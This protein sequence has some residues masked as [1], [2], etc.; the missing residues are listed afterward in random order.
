M[1]PHSPD[2]NPLDFYL[3]DYLKDRVYTPP[4]SNL[5]KLK[6][7]VIREIRTIRADTCREV[8]RNFRDRIQHVIEKKGGHLEH[9]L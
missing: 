5:Q 3:C 7:A 2:L 4:Q 1:A 6:T 8:V 9:I